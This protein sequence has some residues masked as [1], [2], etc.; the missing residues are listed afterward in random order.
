ML[1]VTPVVCEDAST[2]GPDGAKV[3][4]TLERGVTERAA[5]RTTVTTTL[6]A[7]IKAEWQGRMVS[8]H[9]PQ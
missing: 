2:A 5:I 7:E 4:L 3:A 1:V 6:S 9:P 8:P